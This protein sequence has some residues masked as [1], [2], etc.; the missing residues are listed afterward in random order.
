MRRTDSFENEKTKI[1]NQDGPRA[2]KKSDFAIGKKLGKGQYG[3]VCLV[4]HKET[5]FL[6]G[7]KVMSKKQIK[8]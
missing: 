6:C 7:L 3:E 8:E 5:G 4:I 2:F 1:N